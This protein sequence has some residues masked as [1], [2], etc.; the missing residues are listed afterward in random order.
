MDGQLTRSCPPYSDQIDVDACTAADIQVSNVPTAVDGATADT[1][2]FLLLGSLRQFALAQTNLY[3]G[4]FNAGLPM[5]NDPNGKLLGIVGMGGIGRALCVR[6][7]AL[8]MKVQY[9][10]R[11]RL[12]PELEGGATY[13]SFDELLS[14]SDVVSLNLP[15]NAKTKHTMGKAQFEQMK[16][17]AVLINTARGGVVD[18]KAL[19]AALESG[20]IAGCGLDVYEN[21]P[22]VEEGLLKS[23]KAF[24]LPH[25]GYVPM[26]FASSQLSLLAE[27][28]T[29]TPTCSSQNSYRRD[30]SRDGSCLLAKH[31][32]WIQDGFFGLHRRG[33]TRQVLE[34]PAAWRVS[35]SLSSQ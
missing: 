12:A 8:G 13:V 5:S 27:T 35:V 33:A 10:N 6:A 19:V 17:S 28:S 24:L 7:K 16:K 4:A 20:D 30:T 31:R 3:S 23:T 25:V 34:A 26:I 32:D 14:T 2:L 11:N 1:A 21:E 15:L 18:E 22:V 29:H 9:Y